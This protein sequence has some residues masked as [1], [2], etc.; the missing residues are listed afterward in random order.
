MGNLFCGADFIRTYDIIV[1]I[2][3]MENDD[4]ECYDDG[5]QN[6]IGYVNVLMRDQD[7]T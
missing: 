5:R 6:L 7:V 3:Q 2:R 1:Q 4:G